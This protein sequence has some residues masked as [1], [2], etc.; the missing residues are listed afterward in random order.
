[1]SSITLKEYFAKAG[2]RFTDKDAQVI[3]PELEKLTE[4][5]R[6]TA[7]DIVEVAKDSESVLHPYFEWKDEVAASLYR[8]DQARHM[9]NS[10]TIV[11]KNGKG[12]DTEIRAFHAVKVVTSE[13]EQAQKSYTS[14]E[15][16]VENSDMST[17]IIEESRKYLLGWQERYDVYRSMIPEF[18]TEFSSISEEI[19][20]LSKI[21]S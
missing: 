7:K 1:M 11:V 10:I 12:E 17:Q 5:G 21:A 18:N 6:S 14:I 19:N 2:S 20:K 4:E 16:I 15:K 3:G 13:K 8:E 9:A